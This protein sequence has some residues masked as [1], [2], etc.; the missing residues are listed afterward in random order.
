[1]TEIEI[2]LEKCRSKISWNDRSEIKLYLWLN[3]RYEINL[4]YSKLS[5]L[6]LIR[7]NLEEYLKLHEEMD[8][9]I[10][11]GCEWKMCSKCGKVFIYNVD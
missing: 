5:N 6:F 10:L 2:I 8:K 11:E 1:L 3:N 7:N 9:D 4:Y